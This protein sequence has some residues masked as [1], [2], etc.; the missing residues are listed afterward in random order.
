MKLNQ[1]YKLKYPKNNR[2]TLINI[3]TSIDIY[4]LYEL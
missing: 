2:K 3:F 1:K 4:A